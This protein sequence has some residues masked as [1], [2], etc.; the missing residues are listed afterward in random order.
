MN[1]FGEISDESDRRRILRAHSKRAKNGNLGVLK[2][3]ESFSK[4]LDVFG[5]CAR[6][7]DSIESSLKMEEQHSTL[8]RL[9]GFKSTH[10]CLD[11]TRPDNHSLKK[12]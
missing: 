10:P 9:N 12:F 8:G 1:I 4:K 3:I 7:F 5:N 11:Q 6:D 2:S